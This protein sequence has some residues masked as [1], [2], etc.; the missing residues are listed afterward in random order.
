MEKRVRKSNGPGAA[1]GWAVTI[2]AICVIAVVWKYAVDRVYEP[3]PSTSSIATTPPPASPSPTPAPTP[4]PLKQVNFAPKSF[5]TLTA[6]RS[7][8]VEAL[9]SDERGGVWMAASFEGE[10]EVDKFKASAGLTPGMVLIRFNSSGR[11]ESLVALAA[12]GLGRFGA[13]TPDGDGGVWLAGMFRGDLTVGDRMLSEPW[14][15]GCFV[16]RFGPV[17]EV[18]TALSAGNCAVTGMSPDGERGVNCAVVLTG[19]V[20]LGSLSLMPRNYPRQKE[21]YALRLN[22]RGEWVSA[23][24]VSESGSLARNPASWDGARNWVSSAGFPADSMRS[25]VLTSTAFDERGK[26]LRKLTATVSGSLTLTGAAASENGQWL[27][28]GFTGSARLGTKTLNAPGPSDSIFVALAGLD[29]T[30]RSAWSL[31]Q[32]TA[33]ALL[34]VDDGVIVVGEHTAPLALGEFSNT[35]TGM[36]R[37]YVAFMRRD[38]RCAGLAGLGGAGR[39]S[40]AGLSGGASNSLWIG[41]NA[42]GKV[43]LDN[44]RLDTGDR[45]GSMLVRMEMEREFEGEDGASL[46]TGTTE[47]IALGVDVAEL[48]ALSFRGLA[49]ITDMRQGGSGPPCMAGWTSTPKAIENLGAGLPAQADSFAGIQTEEGYLIP[50]LGMRRN[51]KDDRL[52]ITPDTAG[53]Y[54]VAGERIGSFAV[55]DKTSGKPNTRGIFVVNAGPD[56]VIKALYDVVEGDCT[57]AAME[58]DGEGGIW[59]TGIVRAGAV[60]HLCPPATEP[61]VFLVH[62]GVSSYRGYVLP[63]SHSPALARSTLGGVFFSFEFTGVLEVAGVH[64]E[65]AIPSIAVILMKP[66]GAAEWS[67]L[68]PLTKPL[69]RGGIA[70]RQG[71]GC[72]VLAARGE[73]TLSLDGKSWP[74]VTGSSALIGMNLNGGIDAVIEGDYAVEFI[75]SPDGDELWCIGRLA[76][77]VPTRLGAS[78][79]AQHAGTHFVGAF[80]PDGGLLGFLSARFPDGGDVLRFYKD[81]QGD[82]SMLGW[83]SGRAMLGGFPLESRARDSFMARLRYTGGK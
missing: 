55:N 29:G 12:E 2:V 50:F 23:A 17:G 72:W 59:M 66:D 32:G 51:T 49:L 64:L 40:V 65:A 36:A 73:D 52:L 31:G 21:V 75:D 83:F 26:V 61:S 54:W 38:G 60:V 45:Q 48:E 44:Q 74:G 14:A 4:A 11:A 5:T 27:S 63:G 42:V 77:T 39:S 33:S 78:E 58:P 57:L 8:S 80:R 22:A 37:G 6:S 68:V 7:F 62:V 79:F 30:W 10:L 76:R 28:G 34:Q 3:I 70:M 41:I 67:Q 13:L 15:P 46:P 24:E 35:H 25:T 18:L 19:P 20:M 9:C 43:E 16:A 81:L 1:T 82:T 53:S 47:S 71:G 69:G 56:P